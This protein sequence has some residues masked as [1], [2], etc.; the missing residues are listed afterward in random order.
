MLP[1][2]K[3][4][5]IVVGIWPYQIKIGDVVIFHHE[6]M[7]KIKRIKDLDTDRVYLVGDN[8]ADSTDSRDFGW[9]D[10]SHIR[11]KVLWV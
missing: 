1:T 4:N 11:A 9:L 2:F 8:I 10:R 3:P 5:N 6:G 7:D